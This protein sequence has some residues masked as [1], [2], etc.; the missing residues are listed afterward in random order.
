MP[1]NEETVQTEA[2]QVSKSKENLERRQQAGRERLEGRWQPERSQPVLEAGNVQYEVAGRAQAVGCG[3]LGMLQTVVEVVGLRE[4]LDASLQLFKRHL[5]YHESDHVLSLTYNLLTGGR[6]LE[7]LE[8]RRQDVAYLDALGAR[9]I[10]DPT[11]AGDFLRRFDAAAV[12][13]LMAAINQTRAG[14][15]R[16]QP[17][18]DRQLATIDVDGSIVETSG[19]CKERMDVSYDGRWGYG[20]LL[21]SLANTQEVLFAVNRPASRPSHDGAARW[22]DEAITWAREAAGFARVRLRG[23][24]D[25][26]LTAHFDRWTAAG[27]EFVFG[28]DAMPGLVRRAQALPDEA[29]KPMQRNDKRHRGGRRRRRAPDVKAEVVATKGYRTLTLTEEHIAE[30]AYR[31]RACRQPYRLIV[32]R[33]RIRVT[34]G[35][36]HL[37]DEIRY[38]FYITNLPA[39]QMS[40]RAVV[41]DNNAR[42]HQENL[43]EQLKNGVAATRPPVREFDANWAYLVIG[44]L[45]WNLKCWAALLLPAQFGARALLHMEFRRFLHEIVMLPAQIVSTGR[46]LVF[47]LLA[48][49]RWTALLLEG[50]PQLRR[51]C[52]P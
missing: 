33:K 14:V 30:V 2:F 7:D 43:I 17:R 25:F 35:Q 38:F 32:L 23:D 20:P 10:P 16:A 48:I 28:M 27:V 46:R 41:R 19:H 9:R 4:A 5:P 6:C 42:C 21:V 39:G 45:A 18:A 31:P 12:E 47:R 44:A 3:G 8:R 29:W 37:E 11:T 51:W 1:N 24:T 34:Q 40:P 15:W 49:N 22:L 13:A 36:L 26:S 50:T 52:F